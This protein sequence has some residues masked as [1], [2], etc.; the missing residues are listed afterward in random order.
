MKTRHVVIVA[1]ALLAGSLF[2][3]V[4]APLLAL[5]ED[6]KPGTVTVTGLGS[7]DAIPDTATVSFGVV[8][9]GQT[10]SQALNAN[11]ASAERL[12][13][14]LRSAGIAARDIQ[15]QS[16]SLSPRTTDRGDEIVGYT[17]SNT[18]SAK[19][20]NLSRTGAVIDAAVNAGANS[21]NGPALERSNVTELYR[22]ALKLALADARAKAQALGQA[23]SFS[24]GAISSVTEGS[25][26]PLPVTERGA[27][28]ADTPIEPGTQQ[29][30]ASVSVSFQ[31]S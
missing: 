24:V 19:V 15:T 17:A 18:V 23:G 6:P 14:A 20:R 31:I 5:A 7:V 16:V 28:P 8:T 12:I 21:V 1:A 27:A 11:S 29:I 3:G 10:A 26:S 30:T 25:S 2:A 22:E 9:Q 13:A 4:G